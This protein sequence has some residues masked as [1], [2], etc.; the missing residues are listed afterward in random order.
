MATLV[1]PDRY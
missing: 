1:R